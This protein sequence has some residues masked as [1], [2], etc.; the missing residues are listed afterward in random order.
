MIKLA[1][2]YLPQGELS[3]GELSDWA[4]ITLTPALTNYKK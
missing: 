1:K 4:H 2:S 3:S